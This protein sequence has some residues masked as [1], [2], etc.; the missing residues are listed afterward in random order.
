MRGTLKKCVSPS[1]RT[2]D[3]GIAAAR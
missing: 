2:A 1:L 3:A